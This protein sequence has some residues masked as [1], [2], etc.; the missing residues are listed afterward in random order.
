MA[1][2]LSPFITRRI[3]MGGASILKDFLKSKAKK[4]LSGN[5]KK[6]VLRR[7]KR[8]QKEERRRIKKNPNRY[9]G[10]SA[11]PKDTSSMRTSPK[12]GSLP[13]PK[14]KHSQS[15]QRGKKQSEGFKKESGYFKKD[16][17]KAKQDRR[18]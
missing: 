10:T 13:S 5:Q 14:V 15:I 2:P 4:A 3:V 17:R 11:T 8:K 16:R 9:G 6:E 7:L 12:D 1:G 18:G